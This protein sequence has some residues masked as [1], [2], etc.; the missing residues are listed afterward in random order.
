[1]DSNEMKEQRII[2]VMPLS[3]GP[4]SL[5]LT[6]P[7][8]RTISCETKNTE[9]NCFYGGIELGGNIT[10]ISVTCGKTTYNC[11]KDDGSGSGG[12][13]PTVPEPDPD[14]DNGSGSGS[15]GNKPTVPGTRGGLL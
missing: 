2:P 6:C 8:G 5:E 10:Y 9:E 13:K 11:N 4:C 1:M 3:K 15:G 7:D 12:N 14:P